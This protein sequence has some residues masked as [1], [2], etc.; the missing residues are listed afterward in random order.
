MSIVGET[1]EQMRLEHQQ[2]MVSIARGIGYTRGLD[3]AMGILS[4]HGL[5]CTPVW[6]ALL[7]ELGAAD[8]AR[9]AE[10]VRTVEHKPFSVIQGGAS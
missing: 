6:F 3:R 9:A 8:D 1:L 7:N 10:P 2:R 4:Q 5:A